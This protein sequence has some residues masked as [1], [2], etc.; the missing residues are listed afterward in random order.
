MTAQRYN[1]ELVP[2]QKISRDVAV[3]MR[4]KYGMMVKRRRRII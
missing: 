1:L 2:K 4:P 3:T